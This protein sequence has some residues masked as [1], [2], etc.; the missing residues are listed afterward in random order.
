[1]N[2]ILKN[3][4]GVDKVL[5]R[6]EYKSGSELDLIHTL[7][8]QSLF[9]IENAPTD[10]FNNVRDYREINANNRTAKRK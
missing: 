5:K 6:M 2:L 7:I 3:I 4:K 10:L 8:T 1:M 9:L